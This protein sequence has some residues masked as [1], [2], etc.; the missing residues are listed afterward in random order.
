MLLS[1][2]AR[3]EA[4]VSDLELLTFL[5]GSTEPTGIVSHHELVRGCVVRHTS[6]LK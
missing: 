4:P 3:S 1:D 2:V 6:A 5:Q